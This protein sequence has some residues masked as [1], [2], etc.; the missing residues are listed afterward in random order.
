M[1]LAPM[2]LWKAVQGHSVG[3][4]WPYRGGTQSDIHKHLRSA[5]E[6]LSQGPFLETES[7]FVMLLDGCCQS[8]MVNCTKKQ[9]WP[10]PVH[11]VTVFLCAFA[12]LAAFCPMTVN[13]TKIGMSRTMHLTQAG[14]LPPGDWVVEGQWLVSQL[15]TLGFIV[16]S[17]E[18][19]SLLLPHSSEIPEQIRGFSQ[20]MALFF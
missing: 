9:D 1:I 5:A 16:P 18:E 20:F 3:D 11:G 6:A 13:R 14:E 7:D 15:E 19:L 17:R 12:P 2:F 4:A 8:A 10:S